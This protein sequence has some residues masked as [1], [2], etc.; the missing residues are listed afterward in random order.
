MFAN[1]FMSVIFGIEIC[2]LILYKIHN[3]LFGKATSERNI[4]LLHMGRII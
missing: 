3:L 4:T 2:N 1:L